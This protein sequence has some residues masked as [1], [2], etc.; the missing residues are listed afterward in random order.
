M[1]CILIDKTKDLIEKSISDSK[2]IFQ[3]LKGNLDSQEKE[4]RDKESRINRL[5]FL[6]FVYR[7]SK[8]FGGIIIGVGIFLLILGFGYLLYFD[9]GPM[10]NFI[11]IVTFITAGLIIFSGIFHLLKS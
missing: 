9:L 8:F 11:I 2:N 5:E 7:A 3:E 10:N 6:S 4:I 1:N